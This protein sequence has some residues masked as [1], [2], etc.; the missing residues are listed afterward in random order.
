MVSR[1]WGYAGKVLRIDLTKRKIKREN[2]DFRKVKMFLGGRGLNVKVLF[3]E[4]EPEVSPLDPENRLIFGVGPLTGTAAPGSRC[5]VTA[6]SPLTGILGTGNAGGYF[7]PELKFAGF[8]QVV[9]QGRSPKPVYIWISDGEVEIRNADHLWGM[10]VWDA[11]KAI[12]DE[13]GDEKTQIAC[14][15]PA[16]ERFVKMA[17]IIFNLGRA[18][19]RGGIGAVMGSK[20]LK[21]IAVR[22]T[23]IVEIADLKAFEEAVSEVYSLIMADSRTIAYDKDMFN[24]I[25][26]GNVQGWLPTRNFTCGIFERAEALSVEEYWKKYYIGTTGCF[27]CPIPCSTFFEIKSGRFAGLKAEG[28]KVEALA[29]FGCRCGIDNFEAI[30]YANTLCNKLGLDVIS[31][32][33]AIAFAMECYEK[34]LITKDES[35][36]IEIKFG[37][38][39]AV[40]RLIEKIAFREGIGNLL[41]EGAKNAATIIGRGAEKFAMHSKGLDVICVDP[42]GCKSWGLAY[43]VSTRG[44]CHTRSYPM[45]DILGLKE[46]AKTLFGDEKIIDPYSPEGKGIMV[47]W[48]E[49]YCAV[50]DSVGI[51]K[52]PAVDIYKEMPEHV[53]KMLNAATGWNLRSDEL[54]SIGERI[55]HVEKA[56]NTRL[57]LSRKDDT[58]PE[59]F[60]KEPMPLGPARGNVVELDNMLND[61]YRVRGWNVKTG[62]PPKSKYLQLGIATV[63]RSIQSYCSD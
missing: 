34:S 5:E 58:L 21:A 28:P 2:I 31:T 54:L 36:G 25:A 20:N 42:R 52:F 4:V 35:D 44:A 15:G 62:L 29:D 37:N 47:K 46:L 39:E 1:L 51:C 24:F 41:A 14:I 17:N 27:A 32:S 7:G 50:L 45:M 23:G 38:Y 19:G 30:L 13:V 10:S 57:G 3:D 9:I 56:Y 48:G 61:Y 55:I 63:W 59:R 12:K 16:G 18:A 40:I 49:D 26:L 8:D 33:G 53:A 43:A 22:G 60:T 6:K 11:D